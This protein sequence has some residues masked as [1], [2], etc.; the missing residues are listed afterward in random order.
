MPVMSTSPSEVDIEVVLA[1]L[2][3]EESD[4]EADLSPTS[5]EQRNEGSWLPSCL[6]PSVHL[7]PRSIVGALKLF[8]LLSGPLALFLLL[9]NLNLNKHLLASLDYIQRHKGPGA[10]I[11]IAIYTVCTVIL[12]PVSLL[13][14]AAGVI[15]QPVWLGVAISML[16][17]SCGSMSC[18]FLGRYLFR[19]RVQGWLASKGGRLVAIDRAIASGDARGI[20]IL[21]RMSPIVPF[22]L[23]N[24]VLSLTELGW[25]DYLGTVALGSLP[26]TSMAV[27][28]GSFLGDLAGASVGYSGFDKRTKYLVG[29][30]GV[31][32]VGV[33]SVLITLLSR[34]ALRRV[35]ARRNSVGGMQMAKMEART[36]TESLNLPSS[37][38]QG[39]APGQF[40]AWER[41]ALWWTL[42][43]ALIGLV[44]GCPML[45]AM[46]PEGHHVE[47][48]KM[49]DRVVSNS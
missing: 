27:V 20:V 17:V 11:F 7:L 34:R 18:F 24:Y 4:D 45:L 49:S 25:G 44:V 10:L 36:S 22:A 9:P 31:L 32:V 6:L 39:Q 41:R 21:L 16:A 8:L 15:F 38:V 30:I 26:S 2:N 37:V 35:L 13:S 29:W 42:I 46:T 28:M 48:A 3:D 5:L 23:L 12:L 47:G 19:A 14:I 1:D 43:G 40:T 33:T